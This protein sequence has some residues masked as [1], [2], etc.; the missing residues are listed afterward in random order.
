[1]KTRMEIH[2]EIEELEKIQDM[3]TLPLQ[4]LARGK[5]GKE[6]PLTEIF[7]RE[8]YALLKINRNI[9]N[10]IIERVHQS[11]ALTSNT[12]HNTGSLSAHNEQ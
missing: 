4:E 3:L 6:T 12:L 1:M 11:A 7:E 10:E 5:S 8:Y 2:G 9:R